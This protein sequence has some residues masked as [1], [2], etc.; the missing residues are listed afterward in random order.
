MRVRVRLKARE[1]V[2]MMALVMK[3]LWRLMKVARSK[4][5]KTTKVMTH[6]KE[7]M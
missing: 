2:V 7:V 1:T 4:T 6:D 5:T 3:N